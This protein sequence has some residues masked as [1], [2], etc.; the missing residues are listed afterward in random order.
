MIKQCFEVYSLVGEGYNRR[1]IHGYGWTRDDADIVGKFAVTSSGQRYHVS[2]IHVIEINGRWH[3]VNAT[4]ISDITGTHED[5]P[6]S[7]IELGDLPKPNIPSI[8]I[9][10]DGTGKPLK[11]GITIEKAIDLIAGVYCTPPVTLYSP[12]TGSEPGISFLTRD[13]REDEAT[14]IRVYNWLKTE[15]EARQ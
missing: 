12:R 2:G 6:A 7:R 3:R 15:I 10:N 5:A 4:P 11:V 8:F 1:Q 14:Q 13:L 9:S